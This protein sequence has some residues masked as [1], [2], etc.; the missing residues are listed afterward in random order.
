MIASARLFALLLL[1][2]LCFFVRF[3]FFT[4]QDPLTTLWFSS[5]S[6]PPVGSVV[7]QLQ[8]SV[9]AVVLLL[10]RDRAAKIPEAILPPNSSPNN[11]TSAL[12]IDLWWAILGLNL[13]PLQWL[14]SIGLSSH[15]ITTFGDLLTLF[16]IGTTTV[17]RH[18]QHDGWDNAPHGGIVEGQST[19][20]PG[21]GHREASMAVSADAVPSS[22]P[23]TDT[24][25][26]A[27]STVSFLCDL[28]PE[29]LLL[30]PRHL[31]IAPVASLD[32]L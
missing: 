21:E 13:S 5:T 3:L 6:P 25:K 11:S 8:T 9:I 31:E 27:Q 2:L 10:G 26:V 14:A 15:A 22:R 16:V 12:L 24:F 4:P 29:N 30:S 20:I 7:A 19:E 32:R 23:Q 18:R 28:V 1:L 17:D